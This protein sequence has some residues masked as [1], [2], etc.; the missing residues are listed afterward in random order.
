MGKSLTV[1]SVK[2]NINGNIIIG[3]ERII[4]FASDYSI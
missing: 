3:M 1:V 4:N 2:I